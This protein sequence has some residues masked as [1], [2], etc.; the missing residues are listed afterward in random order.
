MIGIGTWLIRVGL[1]GYALS[2]PI[3]LSAATVMFLMAMAGG[4]LHWIDGEWPTTDSKVGWAVLL[5]FAVKAVTGFFAYDP[6]LGMDEFF[7]LWPWLLI[8]VMPYAV[9]TGP[10]RSTL[11]RVFAVSCGVFL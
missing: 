7:H 9:R 2:A 3:S 10:M 4:V 5:Y 1:V 6:R 11:N 8:W